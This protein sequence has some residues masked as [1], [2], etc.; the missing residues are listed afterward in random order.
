M[1]LNLRRVVFCLRLREELTR[2]RSLCCHRYLCDSRNTDNAWAEMTCFTIFDA[3][4]ELF[5]DLPFVN[6]VRCGVWEAARCPIVG[7][8]PARRQT[9]LHQL[10]LFA[11][12]P[13]HPVRRCAGFEA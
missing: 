13:Y 4:G 1:Y 5:E 7:T 11:L 3:S 12:A 10:T 6:K 9:V 8:K 2:N